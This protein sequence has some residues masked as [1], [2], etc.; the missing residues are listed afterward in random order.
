MIGM[1]GRTAGICFAKSSW[2]SSVGP[3][4]GYFEGKL[5]IS[6]RAVERDDEKFLLVKGS[7]RKSQLT[8]LTAA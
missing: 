7:N 2:K 5:G 3:I 8:E 6:V 4:K 1:A